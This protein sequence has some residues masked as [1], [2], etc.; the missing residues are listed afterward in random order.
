MKIPVNV[1]QD[2]DPFPQQA[3]VSTL[4]Q[5]NMDIYIHCAMITA[6]Q[7]HIEYNYLQK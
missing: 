1:R 3:A 2:L 4:K 7:T 5:C 6:T